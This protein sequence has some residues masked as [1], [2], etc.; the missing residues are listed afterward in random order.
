MRSTIELFRKLYLILPPLVPKEVREKMEHALLHLEKDQTVTVH[1]IEDTMVKFGYEVW[2]W[3]QAFKE[4]LTLAETKVG[5]HFLIPKLSSG[6]KEKYSTF[7][8]YGGTFRDLHS[9]RPADFFSI[10][11]RSELRRALVEIQNELRDFAS[12]D[13]MGVEKSNY[14]KRVDEFKN[15]LKNIRNTLKTL[16]ELAESEQDHPAL[17]DEIR[18]K[19]KH[20]EHSLCLLAPELDYEAVDL[21]VQFFHGRKEDLN[22]MKGIHLPSKMIFKY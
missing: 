11:E 17:A 1:E 20:F 9:G 15:L 4:Y 19:V 10:D 8:E 21:S 14:L 16:F 18:S 5:E 7:K 2:P 3:N 12:R 6:L 13:V 22:R